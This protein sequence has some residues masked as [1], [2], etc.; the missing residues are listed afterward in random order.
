MLDAGHYGYRN[1]SPVVPEYYESQRMWRLCEY[2]YD[3]LKA[4]GFEVFKTR[5]DIS[6]DLALEKRGKMAKG[7]ELFISL[8]SNAVG[9]SGS[10]ET[11]RVSVYAPY[12]NRNDSHK[13][14]LFL[15][16]TVRDCMGVSKANLKT[17]KSEK[18]NYEYYGVLRGASKVACPLYYIIEHSFHTNTYAA[19]WLMNDSN[20]QMLA[21]RE[22][23]TI[24]DYFGYEK[25]IKKGDLDMN[26]KIDAGDIISLKRSVMGTLS[27]DD[28]QEILADIDESGKVDIYDYIALKREYMK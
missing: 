5:W 24:A 12:D 17:R 1:Q 8:H 20:L 4:Y 25:P 23:Q 18:G 15:A 22:A 27:L 26:G 16:E 13:L 28:K 2:L 11:D 21:E 7:C 19:K 9:K 10:E 3:E 14:G 6:R